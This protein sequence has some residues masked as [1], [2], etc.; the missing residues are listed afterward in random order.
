M[1]RS[2]V[3]IEELL[4]HTAWLE[5]LAA[6]L[7]RGGADAADLVQETWVAALRS[8]PRRSESARPWLA[9]VL[10]RSLSRRSRG[11]RR[12]RDREIAAGAL[13]ESHV[14]PPALERLRLQRRLTELVAELAEPLRTTLVMRYFEGKTS[15]EVAR[16][17]GVPEGTVRWRTK[18][19]LDRLREQLDAD[20]GGDRGIW[21]FALARLAPRRSRVPIA[22]AAALAVAM[23]VGVAVRLRGGGHETAV[24]APAVTL[25]R[26]VAA[27]EPSLAGARAKTVRAA[28]AVK[29]LALAS[30]PAPPATEL[31][32]AEAVW[33]RACPVAATDG[34]CVSR[35]AAGGDLCPEARAAGDPML[36]VPR[37]AEPR[38]RA[39]Q[40]FERLSLNEGTPADIRAL[41]TLRVAEARLEQLLALRPPRGLAIGHDSS[42]ATRA[43]QERFVA[44]V[45]DLGVRT[46]RTVEILEPLEKDERPIVVA[47]ARL[48]QVWAEAGRLTIGV[49]IPAPLVERSRYGVA[50]RQVFCAQLMQKAQTLFDKARHAFLACLGTPS[51]VQPS[52]TALCRR[53]LDRLPI[54]EK[55]APGR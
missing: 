11:E 5:R 55:A 29:A 34:L 24:K 49:E 28:A 45:K 48:G 23:I 17:L 12:R 26:A 22:L 15:G 32:R 51:S 41:A 10:R 18:A 19:A 25:P 6:H 1:S 21:C 50:E 8:P 27:V 16:A 53:E 39:V 20:H 33:A 54:K 47:T 43:E 3:N 31:A 14:E 35:S 2:S 38:D 36:A 30:A 9:R 37:E 46:K 42:P 52:V 13:E 4:A 40:A 7:V 44:W